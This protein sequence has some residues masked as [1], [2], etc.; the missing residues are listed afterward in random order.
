MK[1]EVCPNMEQGI[2]MLKKTRYSQPNGVI[3]GTESEW[4]RTSRQD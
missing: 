1:A 3:K 2:L 4:K